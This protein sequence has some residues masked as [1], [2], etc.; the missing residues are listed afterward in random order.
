VAVRS[1]VTTGAEVV[2]VL[3]NLRASEIDASVT[4]GWGVDAL[5]GRQTRAHRDVDVGIAVEDVE[6]AIAALTRLGYE[7][8]ADQRPVRIELA[9]DSGRVDMH[10]I[11]WDAERGG[12]QQG[13]ASDVIEYPPGCLDAVG[14]IA[15]RAVRCATADLQVAFHDSADPRPIDFSDMRLLENEV[16]VRLPSQYHRAR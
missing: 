2:R 1:H 3:D 4:G 12:I 10:P 15:D 14:R 8:T 16:G 11:A 13:F 6:L 9:S 5:L 7:I